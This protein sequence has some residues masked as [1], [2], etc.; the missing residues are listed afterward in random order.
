MARKF[1]VSPAPI[2]SELKKV[3]RKLLKL[4]KKSSGLKLRAIALELK[5]LKECYIKLGNVKWP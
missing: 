5:L 1:V 4:K 2:R 3:A